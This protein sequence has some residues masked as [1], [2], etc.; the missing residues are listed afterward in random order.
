MFLEV[1]QR[2]KGLGVEHKGGLHCGRSFM[3]FTDTFFIINI[4]MR[5]LYGCMDIYVLLLCIYMPVHMMFDGPGRSKKGFSPQ[6][7]EVRW[8]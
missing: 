4:G 6:S 8:L 5:Y 1:A 3:T 7:L 2:E